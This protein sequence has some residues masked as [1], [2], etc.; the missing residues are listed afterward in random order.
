MAWGATTQF[1]VPTW[2]VIQG[3]GFDRFKEMNEKD[4]VEFAAETLLFRYVSWGKAIIYSLLA[5]YEGSNNTKKE[6]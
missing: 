5:N 3:E 1:V 2:G 4:A 6:S